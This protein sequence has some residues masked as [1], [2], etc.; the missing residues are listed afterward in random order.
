MNKIRYLL[1]DLDGTL[2]DPKQGLTTSLQYALEKLNAPVPSC[3][4]LTWCI[5]PPLQESFPVLLN[6]QDEAIINQAVNYYL[7]RYRAGGLFENQVYPGVPELLA[8]LRELDYN[9]FVAT[10]KLTTTAQRILQHFNLA[11]Y[12]DGIYGSEPNGVRADKRKLLQYIIE[13]ESIEAT[14]AIMFGDRKHDIIGA[15]HNGMKAGGITYGYGSLEEL[16]SAGADH[17]F[18]APQEILYFLHSSD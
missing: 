13:Q 11:Q 17:F 7:E 6:C 3:D 18:H 8:A 9:L 1:F 10:T 4:E 14:T 15:K 16:T 2:T 5:G 12:F